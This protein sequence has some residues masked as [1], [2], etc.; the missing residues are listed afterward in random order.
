[1]REKDASACSVIDLQIAGVLIAN[2]LEDW[3][4]AEKSL[5]PCSEESGHD[6]HQDC[7]ASSA[8]AGVRLCPAVE[9]CAGPI[10]SGEHGAAICTPQQ[11][12]RTG[13]EGVADPD[14]GWRPWPLG[15]PDDRPR[16]LQ[17]VGHRRLDGESGRGILAGGFPAGAFESRLAS[18]DRIVC[19]DG[20][21]G[22][23]RGWL[24]RTG[25]L[26]RWLATGAQGHD[27]PGR[28]AFSARASRAES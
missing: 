26:Q 22:H 23:R 5:K 6:Q 24:L 3:L 10:S 9:P 16:G 12:D 4:A 17:G 7:R 14:S 8:E 13:L 2:M 1:M 21:A 25:K 15:C 18:T 20:N 28:V 27:G 11:S 19:D